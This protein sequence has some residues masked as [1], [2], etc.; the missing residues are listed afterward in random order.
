MQVIKLFGTQNCHKSKFYK[1]FLMNGGIP[2]DFYDVEVSQLDKELLSFYYPDGQT[3]FPTL[4]IGRKILRNPPQKAIMKH[5]LTESTYQLDEGYSEVKYLA[6]KYAVTKETFNEGRSVK[7]FAKNLKND[8]FISFNMYHTKA[9]LQLKPCEM[10]EEK[11]IDFLKQFE[12]IASQ[13]QE[14][15]G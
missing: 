5:I 13:K 10:A 6:N 14:Q 8:D 1:Q 11:V 2:F 15:M 7:V 9:G 4:I 12:F 3:H